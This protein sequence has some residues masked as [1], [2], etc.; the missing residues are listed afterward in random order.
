MKT[1]LKHAQIKALSR[2]VVKTIGTHFQNKNNFHKNHLKRP[3]KQLQ[4]RGFH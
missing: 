2:I 1:F 4:I 3:I